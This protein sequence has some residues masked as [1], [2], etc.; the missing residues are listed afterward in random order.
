MPEQTEF[1]RV[2]EP[3]GVLKRGGGSGHVDFETG[4]FD[5]ILATDGEASDGHILVMRGAELP[6]RMPLLVQHTPTPMLPALGS[7]IEMR[8]KPHTLPAVGVVELSDAGARGRADAEPGGSDVVPDALAPIRNGYAHMIDKGHLSAVSIRWEGEG[9]L[10]TS[11]PAKSPYF[12]D[13]SDQSL[14]YEKRYGMV[15]GSDKA[16]PWMPK[17]GSVVSVGADPGAT[18]R[19]AAEAATEPVERLY[20][21]SL[22]R[23]HEAHT[24]A[25][26]IAAAMQLVQQG[27]SMLRDQGLD[28]DDLAMALVNFGGLDGSQLAIKMVPVTIGDRVEHVSDACFAQLRGE[29]LEAYR[30]A[31]R[32]TA[33][34]RAVEVPATPSRE[35][36]GEPATPEGRQAPDR[37]QVPE[38]TR[39]GIDALARGIASTAADALKLSLRSL[40]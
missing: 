3:G 35:A 37:E 10:R 13:A 11:L 8:S 28:A 24:E 31:L 2:N 4:R 26:D 9:V 15:F 21:N 5:M 14:S 30:E 18:I 25:P 1:T 6:E 19:E 16:H 34:T 40:R 27:A 32:L 29:S 17:E 33:I 38:F 12:V 23:A 36:E 39:E 20:W 22:L 7:V